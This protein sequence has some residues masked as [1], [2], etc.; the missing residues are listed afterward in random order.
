MI[1]FG[2]D[3]WRG[4]IGDNFTFSNV[5][6]VA[7]AISDYLH[8]NSKSTIKVVVGY[9]RRFLSYE[10]AQIVSCVFAANRIKVSLSSSD[11]P[12]PAVSFHT[13]YGNYNLGIMITASHNPPKFNGLKI[14]TSDGGSADKVLTDKVEKKLGKTKINIMEFSDAVKKRLVNLNDLSKNYIK[15]LKGFV[16]LKAIRKLKL[17]VLV[18]DMYGC[19]DEFAQKIIKP[20]HIRIDYLHNSFNPSFGGMRPE[21]VKSNLRELI[22]KVKRDGYDLGIAL[23]GDADRIAA[24]NKN[25]EFIGA[26][27]LLPLLVIHMVKNRSQR[28]GIGK[29]VVGSNLIDNV[30]LSVG[31]PC[32]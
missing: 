12:T 25:G 1:K 26:Q 27:V 11:I 5:K 17:K 20:S 15:F 2:T 23:D 14:K 16:N 8:Q 10:F 19:G 13:R 22:C 21:P 3:G 9:D 24:V 31:V 28:I 7:Q 18:D 4:I 6:I 29:T 30:E 32:Y